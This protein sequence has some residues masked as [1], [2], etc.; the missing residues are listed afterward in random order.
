MRSVAAQLLLQAQQPP[1]PFSVFHLTVVLLL[2]PATPEGPRSSSPILMRDFEFFS[3]LASFPFA[4]SDR[5]LP[6]L[7]VPPLSIRLSRIPQEVLYGS[8]VL[9]FPGHL[10]PVPPPPPPPSSFSEEFFPHGWRPPV[11]A[12]SAFDRPEPALFLL[13]PFFARSL[14][15]RDRFFK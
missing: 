9:P 3:V 2:T 12:L 5:P 10:T 6:F 8:G 11:D 13:S 7:A 15:R 1:R 4:R 14:L